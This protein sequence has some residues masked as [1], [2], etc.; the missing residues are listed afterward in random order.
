MS[1]F[2]LANVIIGYLVEDAI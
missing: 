1:I 2:I